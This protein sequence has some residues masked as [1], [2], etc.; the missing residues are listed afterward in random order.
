[1]P[2]LVVQVSAGLEWR[3][4][5]NLLGK[6]ALP[7]ETTPVGHSVEVVIDTNSGPL[8]ARL[9]HGGVGKI[10]SAA[11]AQYAIC[12]WQPQLLAL[13]G[14]CGALD[15]SL[16]ELDV[17]VASRTI[18]YDIDA[19]MGEATAARIAR[20][21]TGLPALCEPPHLPP[22]T[23]CGTLLTAD[24]DLTQANADQVRQRFDALAADW[25]SGAVA[26]VCAMNRTP[27]LVLRGVSDIPDA[28]VA[29]QLGKYEQNTP[30]VMERLWRTLGSCLDD[31]L[32][33]KARALSLAGP[34]A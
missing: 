28:D 21:T 30:P 12:T 5:L 22:G 3:S 20:F 16:R 10:H 27:C 6:G 24:H 11:A 33:D 31:G 2:D 26:R 7:G 32:L 14:T 19:G 18:V 29:G 17:I 4:L 1:M 8:A 15:P 13:I 25:E 9:L 34:E 23:R